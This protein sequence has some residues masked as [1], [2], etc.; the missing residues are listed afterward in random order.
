LA[1]TFKAVAPYIITQC[2]IIVIVFLVPWT[3]HQFDNPA[4]MTR[5][6]PSLS[7]EEVERM[8]QEMESSN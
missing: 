1:D 3:V 6:A 7:T 2:V 4:D 8:L 5:P